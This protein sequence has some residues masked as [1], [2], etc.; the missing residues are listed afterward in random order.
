MYEWTR[1]HPG[2]YTRDDGA[3]IVKSS[4]SRWT[5]SH[6]LHEDSKHPSL[7]QAKFAAERI[8]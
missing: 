3:E 8:A 1:V 2:Y 7:R 4:A 5:L 6:P